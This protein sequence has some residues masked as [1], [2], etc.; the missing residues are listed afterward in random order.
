M[1]DLGVSKAEGIV[2]VRVGETYEN[3][4]PIRT[5]KNMIVDSGLSH[6]AISDNLGLS[7]GR[8]AVGTGTTPPTRFDAKLENQIMVSDY[9]YIRHSQGYRYQLPKPYVSRSISLE[10]RTSATVTFTEIGFMSPTGYILFN[11]LLT[12]DEDGNLEPITT[13]GVFYIDLEVRVHLQE[14][15]IYGSLT[16]EGNYGGQQVNW[17]A[18]AA[19]YDPSL[20]ARD[21]YYIV[22]NKMPH[23]DTNG[24]ST[25][26]TGGKR[27][28]DIMLGQID[29][30]ISPMDDYFKSLSHPIHAIDDRSRSSHFS[31]TGGSKWGN[32]NVRRAIEDQWDGPSFKRIISTTIGANAN[33]VE[34]FNAIGVCRGWWMIYLIKFDQS[35]ERSKGQQL[36]IRISGTLGR[37]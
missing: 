21:D 8:A 3:S 37:V 30:D 25:G 4:V 23:I 31:L 14:E 1:V 29:S 24:H 34:S 7:A 5:M 13:S 10:F 20:W 26:D 33:S 18:V 28:P 27:Y 35:I 19:G 22:D 2:T 6:L 36:N 15:K 12:L 32:Y 9:S 11:R 16:V 17:E